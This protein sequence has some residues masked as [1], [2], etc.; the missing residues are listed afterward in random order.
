MCHIH[1]IIRHR[2]VVVHRERTHIRNT[3][4]GVSMAEIS[5]KMNFSSQNYFSSFFKRETGMS[6]MEY[7]KKKI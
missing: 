6:P 1:V 2:A 5:A 4:N 3:S 7:R